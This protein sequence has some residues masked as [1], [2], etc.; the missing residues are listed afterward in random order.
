M[1]IGSARCKFGAA[2]I[3]DSHPARK[4]YYPQKAAYQHGSINAHGAFSHPKY[5]NTLFTRRGKNLS[6]SANQILINI[7]NEFTF[8]LSKHVI[9]YFVSDV[10][11]AD[12]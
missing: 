12:G 3:H 10:D 7:D 5:A 11:H 8:A 6:I 1:Q 4:S 2:N 9:V